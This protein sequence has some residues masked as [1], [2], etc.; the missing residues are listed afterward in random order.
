MPGTGEQK[1]VV[2]GQKL[3]CLTM[4]RT[5]C[6]ST[7]KVYSMTR[8]IHSDTLAGVGGVGVGGVG[9][10]G[11]EGVGPEG[12]GLE[13]VGL[14]AVEAVG[15]E[16]VRVG[17]IRVGEV[18]GVGF[19]HRQLVKLNESVRTALIHP[20]TVFHNN[21]VQYGDTAKHSDAAKHQ[22]IT[23]RVELQRVELQSRVAES[24]CS[25]EVA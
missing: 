1:Q 14:G 18:E 5:D 9:L 12:V 7:N 19:Y 20:S 11:V 8:T 16:A 23:S 4:C 24:S 6:F 15:V 22:N 13:G 3:Y 21:A 17:G 25:V 2:Q 10:G